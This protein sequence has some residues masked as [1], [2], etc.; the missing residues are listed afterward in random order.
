MIERAAEYIYYAASAGDLRPLSIKQLTLR[1][2]SFDKVHRQEIK[3]RIILAGG[4]A[5]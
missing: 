1:I 5:K 4:K 3:N 2:S